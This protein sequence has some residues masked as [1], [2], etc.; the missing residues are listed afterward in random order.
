MARVGGKFG[1]LLLGGVVAY[2]AVLTAQSRAAASFCESYSVG[3][4]IE[5]SQRFDGSFFLTL[6]GPIPDPQSSDTEIFIFCAAMTLCD[7]SCQL[8][9]TN[10]VVTDASF[11][12]L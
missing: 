12:S 8:E 5:D 6:R 9:V 2:V 10:D 4:R 7:V 1:L 3:T 11:R